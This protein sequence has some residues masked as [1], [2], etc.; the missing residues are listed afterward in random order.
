MATDDVLTSDEARLALSRGPLDTD[1]QDL[2]DAMNTAVSQRLDDAVGKIVQGTI[3][4]E[5]HNGG[6]QQLY[7]RY[8]PVVS[9]VQVVEYD[10]TTA[11]TLTAES[12]TSKPTSGYVINPTNGRLGRRSD[13]LD[14]RFP[15][16]YDNVR[17]TYVA[18]RF[19]ETADVD[20]I[21]KQAARLTLKSWW[22]MYE[23]ST[24]TFNEFES[25]MA[26]IPTFSVPKAAKQLL[27]RYW[28]E[29]T[30]IGF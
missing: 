21:F 15:T 6:C 4:G 16:G 3:S 28:R 19:A 13:N 24:A 17:V 22:R 27:A 18:G 25:P 14:G 9:V 12:N 20:E 30:G 10:G 11:G 7:L 2:V 23:N 26:H 8:S 5:L 1:Q 29:G